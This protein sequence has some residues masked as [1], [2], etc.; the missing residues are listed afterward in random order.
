MVREMAGF[1]GIELNPVMRAIEELKRS[2][3]RPLHA[4]Q[5][6]P[7]PGRFPAPDARETP[8]RTTCGSHGRGEKG[9]QP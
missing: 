6:G 5:D 1:S 2:G 8:E 4:C 9:K 3:Y 7:Y